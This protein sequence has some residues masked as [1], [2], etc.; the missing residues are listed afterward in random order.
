MSLDDFAKHF[1]NIDV[2]QRSKGVQDL[3]IDLHEGD[4]CLPHCSGPTKGCSWG[5]CK[6]WCMCKGPCSLYGAYTAACT[7]SLT[8][9]GF[10]PSPPLY[11]WPRPWP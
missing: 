10:K 9:S 4:G 1:D 3:Y 2:C 6:F 11:A 5:C 7:G 8:S